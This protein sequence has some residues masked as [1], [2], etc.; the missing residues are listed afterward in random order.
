M[1][2]TMMRTTITV[3]RII[4]CIVI[5]SAII[6]FRYICVVSSPVWIVVE[7]TGPIMIIVICGWASCSD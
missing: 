5:L 4:A 2:A 7:H 1:I 6:L 3:I